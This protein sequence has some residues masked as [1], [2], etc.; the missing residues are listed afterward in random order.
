MRL[1]LLA[2][3]LSSAAFAQ[4][5][6]CHSR[7]NVQAGECLKTCMGDPKDA[8][9]PEKAQHLQECLKQC[10]AQ[11]QACKSGCSAQK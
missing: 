9:K 1:A 3:V 6:P 11:N 5:S 2:F 10:E 7:C 4:Q 8:S